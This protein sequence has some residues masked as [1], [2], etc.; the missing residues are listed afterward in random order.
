MSRLL[1]LA[2]ALA[3]AL[4]ACG[5]SS[6]PRLKPAVFTTEATKVCRTAQA[7]SRALARPVVPGDVP[8]FLRRAARVLKAAVARLEA[9]RP[10]ARL[11]ALWRQQ[12]AR[13]D[14][15]L[16]VVV[17]L[18]HSVHDGKG[19]A[20]AAVQRVDGQ[21]RSGRAA[22]DAGWRRLGLPGCAAG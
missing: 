11:D 15:Q 5:G 12:T 3:L 22:S 2:L 6:K 18:S 20:V 17:S 13:L 14:R 1:V 10:P 8:V 7:S 4:E 19:D 21:L 9:L 16:A